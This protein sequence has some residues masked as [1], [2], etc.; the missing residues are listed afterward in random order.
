M[1][2]LLSSGA[3]PRYRDDIIRILA[4]PKGADLQF[5][6]DRR[7]IDA[8]L[9]KRIEAGEVRNEEAIVFYL[10]S[11]KEKLHT[12]LVACRFVR[13]TAARFIGSSCII[14]LC[15][16]SFVS[17]LDE[18]KFRAALKPDEVSLLPRWEA[19][20]EVGP[21]L[22]GKFFFSISAKLSEYSTDDIT[23]FEQT[24]IVLVRYKDFIDDRGVLF[25]TVGRVT[26]I[27]GR[28]R[29]SDRAFLPI[30]GSYELRSGEAYEIEVYPFVPPS[31]ELKAARLHIDSDVTAVEFPLGHQLDIDSRY[32]SKRLPFQVQEQITEI[33]AGLRIYVTNPE[34]EDVRSDIL[35]PVR[36]SGSLLFAI[37]RTALIAVGTS[38]TGIIAAYAADKLSF[39]TA[40]LIFIFGSV[41]AI[42]TVFNSLRG[43]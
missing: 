23:A 11:D 15:A 10:W 19:K 14:N 39:G 31:V 43:G 25:F 40:L 38:G 6:Y 37:A 13:V 2:V 16:E 18:S 4:L 8:A 27:R 5:R 33:S 9:L 7:Y 28:G 21:V 30:G 22:N 12:E 32:D 29:A 35:V 36:F 3:T 24:A 17:D 34:N 26:Q 20:P 1:L 41:A 42:G